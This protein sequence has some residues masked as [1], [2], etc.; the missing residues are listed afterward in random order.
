M[1]SFF[2]LNNEYNTMVSMVQVGLDMAP[3]PTQIDTLEKDC[4]DYNRTLAA[5]KS[6]QPQIA[7]LNA[8]LGRS[9]LH[10]LTLTPTKLTEASCGVAPE[11]ARKARK[12][13]GAK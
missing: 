2:D 8:A 13:T 4:R 1:K 3:T 5:W 11:A 10:E 6:A 12:E 7:S 9:Q